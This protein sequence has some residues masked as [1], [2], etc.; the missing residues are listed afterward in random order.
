MP[1]PPSSWYRCL[2]HHHLFYWQLR[3]NLVDATRLS[4]SKLV[5]IKR[6]HTND[7]ESRIALYLSQDL[8]RQDPR[9]HSVPILDLFR[10]D[11]D[12][13]IEY[14]VMPFLSLANEPGFG[15]VGEVVELCEQV[16]EVGSFDLSLT[17][18]EHDITLFITR[19]WCS[20]TSMASP[21]GTSIQVAR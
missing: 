13:G 14:M 4:D 1:E 18:L 17:K 21:T 9:N 2:A 6:V 8:F 19:V 16:L 15:S 12:D 10:D 20:C 3:R 7:S 11:E 5:Y